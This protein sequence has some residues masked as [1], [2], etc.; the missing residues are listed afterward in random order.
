MGYVIAA[1]AISVGS[2]ALYLAHLARERQRLVRDLAAD[3]R[4]H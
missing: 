2:V 1:Y 3:S 4:R